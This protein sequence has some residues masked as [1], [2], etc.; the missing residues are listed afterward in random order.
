MAGT[1]GKVRVRMAP[2]PTGPFH[3]GRSRTAVI[4]WLFARHHGGAF[5]LRI[6]DTDRERSKPEFLQSIVESMRWLGLDWDEGPEKGGP[7]APY[8]QMGR[9]E[10][11]RTRAERLLSAG[12]AYH[13]YC[14]PEELESLRER[15]RVEKRAFRYPGTCRALSPEAR[16]ARER[17]GRTAA[18]RLKVPDAG[19][20]SFTDAVLGPIS[21]RNSELDDLVLMKSDGIPTYHFAVVVDDLTMEI[22]HV[23]RGQDHVPNTPKQLLI[24]QALGAAPP[25]FAHVP[26]VLGM[27]RGKL[28]ARHG[29][30]AL[31]AYGRDGFLPEALLNYLATVGISYEN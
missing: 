2:G 15:A 1:G 8:Y 13:C 24:Y 29:A 12:S 6:E 4:N 9:L 23:I 21:V 30:E 20:T 31:T 27:E 16:A 22:T 10:T 17:E 19:E 26:L 25:I 7:H 11:Y 28:S 14:T 18:V 3:I 5:V